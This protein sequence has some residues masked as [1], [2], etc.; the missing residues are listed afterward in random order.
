M[1]TLFGQQ[2]RFPLRM[3]PEGVKPGSTGTIFDVE[4][5]PALT[6]PGPKVRVQIHDYKSDWIFPTQLEIL[7]TAATKA[8]WYIE[9]WVAGGTLGAAL[10]EKE[11]NPTP[12]GARPFPHEP[13][14]RL[15]CNVR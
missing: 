13:G 10:A 8:G 9:R 14:Y 5:L 15:T 2:A 1:A 3:T 12:Y 11:S 4:Q 6:G 7:T